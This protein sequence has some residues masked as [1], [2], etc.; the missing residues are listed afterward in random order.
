M[1]RSISRHFPVRFWS[2][3]SLLVACWAAGPALPTARAQLADDVLKKVKHGTVHLNVKLANGNTAEGSG[4][5]VDRGMI[6]TNAHV[7]NMHGG[8]K[9]VPQKIEVT[10]DSGEKTSR[11]VTARFKGA[12]YEADLMLLEVDGDPQ[13]LPESLPLNP[14]AELNETQNVY[15]FG[16]PLGKTLGKGITVS[17]SSI[18]SLRKEN[19]ELKEIQLEGGIHEGNSGGPIINEKGEVVGVAVGGVGGTTINFGIPGKPVS[20]LV[21]GK[22]LNLSL[23]QSYLEGASISI[24]AVVRILDPLSRI[25]N[26]RIDY[27]TTPKTDGKPRPASWTRP[28]PAEG[29][30]P[31]Q[32]VDAVQVGKASPRAELLVPPLP[33]EKSAYWFRATFT[34]G[35]GREYWS[36]TI[37]NYRPLPLER[38]EIT[39]QYK[40]T[41]GAKRP[42]EITNDSA[43]KFQVGTRVESLSMYVRAVATPSLSA[44]DADGDTRGSL[45]YNQ[46]SLAMRKNGE[47]MQMKEKWTP[48]GQNFL[49]TTAAFRCAD[50]GAIVY[51]QPELRNAEPKFKSELVGISDLVLQSL[52]LMS[53]SLPHH[54]LQPKQRIRVQKMLLV[55]L[56]EMYVPTHADVKYTYLGVRKVDGRETAFFGLNGDLHPRRGD[57]TQI[58]GGLSGSL[59]VLLDT[60]EVLM[61][62]GSVNVEYD[63]PG[64]KGL[65][66][67]GTLSVNVRPA[68][69]AKPAE[70]A[71][72]NAAK[73]AAGG[74]R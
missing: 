6:I 35:R 29:D 7:L 1:T 42:I 37:S 43:F 64:G 32:T 65:R 28:E 14:E 8:D 44:P 21:N 41:A 31:L 38:R 5:F 50:D 74:A 23:E 15:V 73:P 55:G 39:L 52:E 72:E 20:D 48:L 54:S 9:R 56:P 4:W 51:A 40:S 61:G 2:V 3:F 34:D 10:I 11:A 22:F 13:G 19:G 26:V 25:K 47:P 36:P 46:V 66:L 71:D 70:K 45:R 58:N 16:F 30:G 69:P 33:D 49:K 67:V 27:W 59:D 24:P 18:S 12:A 17:K 57:D 68:P 62:N 53:L 63:V 60:G